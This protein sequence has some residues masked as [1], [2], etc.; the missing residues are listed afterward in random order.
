MTVLTEK[1]GREPPTTGTPAR[2]VVCYNIDFQFGRGKV[3]IALREDKDDLKILSMRSY[4]RKKGFGRKALQFLK[5]KGIVGRPVNIR[6]KADE[7]WV[8]MRSE[9][10]VK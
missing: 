3:R 4:P 6:H 2:P 1:S 9:G 5:E 7:F 8:K 10:L